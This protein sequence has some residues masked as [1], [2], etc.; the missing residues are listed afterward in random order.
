MKLAR[1]TFL[2]RRLKESVS[3]SQ[4]MCA[5]YAFFHSHIS[6]GIMLWGN[7]T[8]AL[9][10]FKWQKKVVRCI[11]GKA[12]RESCR[13][14]FRELAILTLPS[15]YIFHSLLNTKENLSNLST[16]KNVHSYGTRNRN[17]LDLPHVRLRKTQENHGYNGIKLFNKLPA[18]LK[19]MPLDKF[20]RTLK[21]G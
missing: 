4:L 20:K 11:K 14:L 2:L 21:N 13:P 5:Y 12:S 9:D 8:G 17:D 6:Y 10:V 19:D 15:L 3:N 1:V 16:R 18:Q 7:S